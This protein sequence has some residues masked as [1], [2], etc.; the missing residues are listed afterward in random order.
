[1]DANTLRHGWRE[2]FKGVA[3]YRIKGQTREQNWMVDTYAGNYYVVTI[4]NRSPDVFK[5]VFSIVYYLRRMLGI[6]SP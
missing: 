3:N 2:S 6:Q 1:M 4:G 5:S